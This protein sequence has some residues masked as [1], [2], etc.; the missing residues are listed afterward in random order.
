[1]QDAGPVSS[2]N[3]KSDPLTSKTKQN[4]KILTAIEMNPNAYT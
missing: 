3:R 1:M 4:G 2:F